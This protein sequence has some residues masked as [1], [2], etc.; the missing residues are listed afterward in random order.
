[1]TNVDKVSVPRDT[2][3][4]EPEPG[5]FRFIDH[6]SKFSGLAVSHLYL[7]AALATIYE[8]VSRYLFNAPTQDRKSVV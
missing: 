1:M 2:T 3:V 5:P 4:F 6:F 8:V 7:L